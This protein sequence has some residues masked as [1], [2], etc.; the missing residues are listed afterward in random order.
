MQEW[1][2]IVFGLSPKLLN[3][4]HPETINKP[5]HKKGRLPEKSIGITLKLVHY[6]GAGQFPAQPMAS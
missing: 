6:T 3:Q 2:N 1:L 4:E 5:G